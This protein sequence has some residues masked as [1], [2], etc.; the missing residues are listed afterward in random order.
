[1]KTVVLGIT[2]R[3]SLNKSKQHV[4]VEYSKYYFIEKKLYRITSYRNNQDKL[5]RNN[6]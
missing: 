2:H 4:S 5:I 6:E 1:M 3:P